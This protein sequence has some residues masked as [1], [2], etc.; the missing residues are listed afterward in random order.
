MPLE[1]F[2]ERLARHE[3][4]RVTLEELQ[5]WF[6][7][8]H[9][10]CGVGDRR[11]RLREALDAL[12]KEGLVRLPAEGLRNW[13]PI[14]SPSLPRFISLQREAQERTDFSTV[15]WV[16][17]LAFAS[18]LKQ[19]KQL[20]TLV[21]INRFLIE[22]RDRL[23]TLVPYRERALQIFGD[24]K[25]LDAAVKGEWLYG[26][27]PL[28]AI[29]ACHPAPPLPHEEFGGEGPL[30]LVENYHTYW[31]LVRWNT[32]ARR[33]RSIGYGAGNT[34]A[35]SAPAVL[36]WWR[37]HVGAPI[38]YFGDLDPS[39]LA[40]PVLLN[41]AVAEAAQ[42]EAEGSQQVVQLVPAVGLYR[43]LFE[44]G[45]SRPLVTGKRLVAGERELDWLGPELADRARAAFAGHRWFPQEGVGQAVL[46]GLVAG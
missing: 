3:R 34:I 5:A 20:A 25:A 24:E 38:E 32:A 16:P 18:E 9:P 23:T 13:D 27:L 46:E 39:G 30:L 6:A 40:I 10:E 35:K 28:K 43:L 17:A 33:F 22:H 21:Q 45:I 15:P 19:A 7:Q 4:V 31:T 1:P 29:G 11:T 2:R 36:R 26:R 14:G 8:T 44:H 41:N 37:E 42:S 12:C